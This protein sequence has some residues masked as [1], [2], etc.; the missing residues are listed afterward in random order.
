MFPLEYEIPLMSLSQSIQ[1]EN[2]LL[3]G[4]YT[5]AS[6]K[7]THSSLFALSWSPPTRVYICS[8]QINAVESA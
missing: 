2:S 7:K 5:R 1:P 8:I 4:K 6:P 3:I